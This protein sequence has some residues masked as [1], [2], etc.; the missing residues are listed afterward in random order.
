M[1]NPPWWLIT[2]RNPNR[3]FGPG[4]RAQVIRW[5]IIRL[6]EILGI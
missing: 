1:R 6:S 5:L 3:E 2:W 4:R